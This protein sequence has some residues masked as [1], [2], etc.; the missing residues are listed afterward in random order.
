MA[1]LTAARRL[2]QLGVA[3][4]IVDKGRRPG[5]RMATR[6]VD[7][8]RFDHGAQHF[9]VR[10]ASFAGAVESWVESGIAAVWFRSRSVSNPELGREPRHMGTEGMRGIPEH[11]AGGLDVRLATAID[12]LEPTGTG[13]A[14]LAGTEIVGEGSGVILTPPVP[15]ILGV[16]RAGDIVLPPEVDAMLAG[17]SYNATLAVLAQL[18]RASDLPDGHLSPSS[19]PIAWLADNEQ[20]GISSLPALTIHSTP[21]FAAAHLE[22]DPE[23][24]IPI[25][26]ERASPHLD[27]NIIGA[28]GHRWRYA[29]P[30]TTLQSGAVGFRSGGPVVLGGEVFAGARVEGAFQSGLAAAEMMWAML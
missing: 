5:G 15:Q 6:A 21:E 24:W 14:A 20:K 18:D 19:G 4:T 28:A 29:Q 25:L 7:G 3:S 30:R 11:L 27:A 22:A 10:T 12:R 17:V 8:A 2:R 9:S 16:L 1:G 26:C 13:L 23:E